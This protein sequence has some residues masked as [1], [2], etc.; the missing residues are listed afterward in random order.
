MEGGA[1]DPA[2]RGAVPGTALRR[3][4]SRAGVGGAR[5]PRLGAT[6]PGTGDRKAA[7]AVLG[8]EQDDP[9]HAVPASHRGDPV[10]MTP[11]DRRVITFY[12]Y[13]GGVGR[14]M[15]LANVAYRLANT[16]GLK[17]IAVDWDLE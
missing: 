11:P 17:V 7:H 4:A 13:K 10:S 8:A 2:S 14:T 16:H 6:L 12:S 3:R 5:R 15:A 9:R 1:G